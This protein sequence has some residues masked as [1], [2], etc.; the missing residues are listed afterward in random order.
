MSFIRNIISVLGGYNEE[1]PTKITN[2]KRITNWDNVDFLTL[3][4]FWL[5]DFLEKG[6]KIT[7]FQDRPHPSDARLLVP[8]RQEIPEVRPGHRKTADIYIM[9]P[10]FDAAKYKSDLIPY[11]SGN[12]LF[13][14]TNNGKKPVYYGRWVP[15]FTDTIDKEMALDESTPHEIR[16]HI[17]NNLAEQDADDRACDISLAL[18]DIQAAYEDE[19]GMRFMRSEFMNPAKE[20]ENIA[21]ALAWYGKIKSEA[22]SPA[23]E[24]ATISMFVDFSRGE[25]WGFRKNLNWRSGFEHFKD[26]NPAKYLKGL[27]E[28]TEAIKVTFISRNTAVVTGMGYAWDGYYKHQPI[29]CLTAVSPMT[30]DLT[31][32]SYTI[33]SVEL[34][35][36]WS[37]AKVTFRA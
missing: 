7:D 10:K 27:E 23:L 12:K 18:H 25:M 15:A 9:P 20:V 31:G 2:V 33:E 5:K 35:E 24:C 22:S 28:S 3:Y 21:E 17:L 19:H 30:Q 8:D 37:P 16:A 32:Y 13:G 29:I 14:W 26:K 4:N 11:L 34:D 36:E 6:G 1:S